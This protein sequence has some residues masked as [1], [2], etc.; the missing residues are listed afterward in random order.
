MIP[1]QETQT[2]TGDRNKNKKGPRW[3]PSNFYDQWRSN[4]WLHWISLPPLMRPVC[5]P[6]SIELIGAWVTDVRSQPTTSVTLKPGSTCQSGSSPLSPGGGTPAGQEC[7]DWRI[8]LSLRYS[9]EVPFSHFIHWDAWSAL[10]GVASLMKWQKLR[11]G[12]WHQCHYNR[13]IGNAHQD[14]ETLHQSWNFYKLTSPYDI[15][16]ASSCLSWGVGG[17]APSSRNLDSD[18][19]TDFPFLLN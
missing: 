7:K 6:S 9:E 16:F 5:P 15:I 10:R 3:S 11:L 13:P 4:S 1:M 18:G 19:L 12:T 8:S 17:R 2:D 14:K